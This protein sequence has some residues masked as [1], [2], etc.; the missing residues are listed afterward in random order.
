MMQ[1]RENEL[2]MKLRGTATGGRWWLA[3][4]NRQVIINTSIKYIHTFSHSALVEI[5]N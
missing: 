2:F 4:E 1:L 5:K 3:E